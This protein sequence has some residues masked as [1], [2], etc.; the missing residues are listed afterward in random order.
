M[1]SQCHIFDRLCLHYLT[2][3]VT[4]HTYRALFNCIITT[5]DRSEMMRVSAQHKADGPL[6]FLFFWRKS[7]G[8]APRMCFTQRQNR[9]GDWKEFARL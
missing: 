4:A 9:F 6:F 5:L 3:S 1:R 8:M 7:L 2:Y